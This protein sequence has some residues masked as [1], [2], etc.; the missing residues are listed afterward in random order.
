MR[1]KSCVIFIGGRVLKG[2]YDCNSAVAI[3]FTD[4]CEDDCFGA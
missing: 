4:I 1:F 3:C 2:D